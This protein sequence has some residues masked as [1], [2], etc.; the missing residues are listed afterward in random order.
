MS[1]TGAPP[2]AAA[3][4]SVSYTNLDVYK[5]QVQTLHIGPFDAEAE[6]LDRMHHQ[7]IPD[8]GLRMA[9]RHHEIY[10][11]D[12]RRT[13]PEKLRTILRQPVQDAGR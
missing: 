9:G 4:T 3:S 8:N 12:P 13:A 1:S 11:S 2:S 6:V 5:R 7:F 10:L